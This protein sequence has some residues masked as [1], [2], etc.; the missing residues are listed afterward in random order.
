MLNLSRFITV[1]EP[2]CLV[3]N[4]D[5]VY[6]EKMGLLFVKVLDWFLKQLNETPF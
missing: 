1:C 5:I 3:N 4:V 2:D 6:V